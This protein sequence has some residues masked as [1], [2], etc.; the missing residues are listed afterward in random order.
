MTVYRS[1]GLSL[2]VTRIIRSRPFGDISS[3]VL[4]AGFAGGI[5]ADV[6]A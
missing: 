5:A 1:G 3:E 4:A 6:C 2:V